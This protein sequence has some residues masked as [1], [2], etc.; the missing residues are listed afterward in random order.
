MLRL[1]AECG[2]DMSKWPTAKHFTSWLCLAPGNTISGGRLLSS[3]TRRSSNRAATLLRIAAVNIGRTQTALG[4]FYRR[5]AVRT[6]K[7]KAVTAT[8][9]KRAVLFY[10]ALRHGLA[11]QAPGA[12]S[13]EERY[14]QRAVH[15][16]ERRAK[17]LGY[18]LVA[19]EATSSGVSDALWGVWVARQHL[20][21]GGDRI[22]LEPVEREVEARG[23]PAALLNSLVNLNKVEPGVLAHDDLHGLGGVGARAR[24][25]LGEACQQ[26]LQRRVG[27]DHGGTVQGGQRAQLV[28]P[29]DTCHQARARGRKSAVQR[30]RAVSGSRSSVHSRCIRA[31]GRASAVGRGYGRR[32]KVRSSIRGEG[33]EQEE[34]M[35][36]QHAVT[37]P[38]VSSIQGGRAF[39]QEDPASEQAGLLRV[40]NGLE[41]PISGALDPPGDLSG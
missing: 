33:D 29:F 23:E 38:G 8:A 24:G 4:A 27:R 16:L 28:G 19:A 26:V 18:A 37:V 41:L 6:G 21:V 17:Q 40:T 39:G 1:I 12:S 9:R 13:Y 20:A 15:N 31:R 25:F 5:L 32:R 36:S 22:Q 11:Y 3:R 14:R 2:D 10:N 35:G 34:I 7:A 30:K